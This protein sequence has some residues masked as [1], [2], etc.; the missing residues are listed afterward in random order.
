MKPEFK[1]LPFEIKEIDEVSGEFNGYAAAFGNIDLGG[2]I[3][4][5]GAFKKTLR[6]SKGRVPILADHN[7]SKQ[8]GWNLEAE[9]DEKG[10][11]VRGQLNL[12]VQM[13]KE[14]FSLMK[15][16]LKLRAKSGLSIGYN[17]IKA[18]PDEKNPQVRR[19]KEV[20]LWEYS[21]VTFPMNQSAYITAAKNFFSGLKKIEDQ[22]FIK[23][24]LE[25]I[26][27]GELSVETLKK[28]VGFE[29]PSINAQSAKS[30]KELINVFK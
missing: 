17:T 25:R 26:E 9:E 27:K 3:I 16:G 14:R 2:D 4:D 22:E 21:H 7:P 11:R 18:I 8:I 10:L 28:A 1:N 23:Q 5:K 29:D 20:K 19:L 13:A 6:E 15:Q 12:D 30:L 24:L